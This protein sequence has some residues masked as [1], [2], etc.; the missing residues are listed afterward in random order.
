MPDRYLWTL[1]RREFLKVAAAAGLTVAAWPELRGVPVFAQGR[2]G[3]VLNAAMQAS[4]PTLDP[5]LTT[6]T[7]TQQIVFHVFE[8]LVTFGEDYSTI[9]PVLAE[10][11][12]VSPDNLTYTFK[13]RQGVRFH[14]GAAFTAED[15]VAS[16]ERLIQHSPVGGFYR[17]VKSVSVVDVQTFRVMLDVPLD[18]L[19]AMAIPVTCQGIMPKELVQRAQKSELR[20]G[21]LIGTGPYKFVEWRPDVHILVDRFPGYR[22]FG[23]AASGFGGRKEALLD[24]IRFIPVREQS[25]RIAGLETG[26]YEYV[27]NL[28]VS[29]RPTL[30][31]NSD[32]SLRVARIQ[33]APAWE[34]NK[35]EAPTSNM[36][37]RQAVLA[38]LDMKQIMSTVAMHDPRFFR[39]QPCRFYPEQSAWHTTA[40]GEMYNQGNKER[41]RRLLQEAGYRGEEIIILSNQ[42]Y[43]WMYRATLAAAPQLEEAGI[44]VRIEFSDWASQ[45]GKAL[46]LKGWHINQSGWSLSFDP[47]QLRGGLQ[48]GAPYAY[49]NRSPKMDEL[50][51]QAGLKQPL[52][53][54]KRLVE[55]IM[56]LI[57]EEVPYIRFGDFFGLEAVR[58][59]VE[60]YRTWY[61]VPR[62]WNVSKA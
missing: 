28:P 46:T 56:K 53:Q 27:E 38:A 55:E 42:N 57:Y 7:A 45:I 29:A 59:N 51:A 17:G 14:N 15:A 26:R 20:I 25:A 41:A 47:V 6:T 54:K 13:V 18:L 44:R 50:L 32:I 60:G 30:A 10:S 9:V 19:A 48:S 8:P 1:S 39:L 16:L 61:V 11:W 40:G 4:P 5:H 23:G 49:G 36:K 2:R 52:E 62:F 3:G 22:P 12:T 34:I 33:W 35:I 21:S 58:A 37:F 31:R 43:D 24:Q